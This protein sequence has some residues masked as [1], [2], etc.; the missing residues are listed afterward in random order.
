[1][2]EGIA[3]PIADLFEYPVRRRDSEDGGDRKNEDLA[4]SVLDYVRMRLDEY[5]Q[6]GIFVNVDDLAFRLRETNKNI[7][8]ALH[9]LES[10]KRASQTECHGLWRLELYSQ[11][12]A[13][14][15]KHKSRTTPGS[16]SEEESG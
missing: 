1:M 13:D 10:Q 15:V 16:E 3:E 12:G 7:R 5:P 9:L 8:N 14:V 2:R 6:L 4:H 11:P